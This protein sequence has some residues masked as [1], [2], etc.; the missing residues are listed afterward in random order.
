MKKVPT[1]YEDFELK[2]LRDVIRDALR[3][4]LRVARRD[5]LRD[6]LRD[7]LFDVITRFARLLHSLYTAPFFLPLP[8]FSLS[9]S[10]TPSPLSLSPAQN[11][12]D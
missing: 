11:V 3:A 1:A 2:F 7:A 4:A 10:F 5:A 6:P 8:S 12:Q 9:P